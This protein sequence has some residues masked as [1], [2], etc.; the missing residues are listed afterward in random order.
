MKTQVSP[1]TGGVG[2]GVGC[3]D[4][5]KNVIRVWA[6]TIK[7]MRIILEKFLAS[8]SVSTT[9]CLSIVTTM[10]T[11]TRQFVI[12]KIT[13]ETWWGRRWSGRWGRGRRGLEMCERSMVWVNEVEKWKLCSI[14]CSAY[15]R[16]WRRGWRG[17]GWRSWLNVKWKMEIR[18]GESKEEK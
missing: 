10:C 6:V 2:G 15:R 12:K 9:F 14:W 13:F 4:E 18:W 5:V 16:S 3:G 17:R 11:K 7:R 8:T 1:R